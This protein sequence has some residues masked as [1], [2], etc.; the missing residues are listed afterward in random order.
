MFF[1]DSSADK[2]ISWEQLIEEIHQETTSEIFCKE[3]DY[4]QIFKKII[5]SLLANREIVLFDFDFSEE[6]TH[7]LMQ[8]HGIFNETYTLE[9]FSISSKS[10]LISQCRQVSENWKIS[11]F[12]SGTTGQPKRIQPTFQSI[13]RFLT[14]KSQPCVWG[15][16]YHPTHMAGLQVFFQSFLNGNTLVRLFGLNKELIHQTIAHSGI[17]HI[18]A[19]PTFYRLLL[20]TSYTHANVQRITA[21]GERF[22]E[23][24]F[25][26]L[27]AIFPQAKI[28]NIYAS[29]EAGAVLVSHGSFFEIKKGWEHLVKIE[30]NELLLHRSVLGQFDHSSEWY[31]TGDLVSF[32]EENPQQFKFASRSSELI[33]VGGY[34]VNPGEVEEALLEIEGISEVWVYGRK[35]AVMGQLVCCEIV[36]SNP[37]LDISSIKQHLAKRLQ[38]FKIPRIIKFVEK[39]DTT[40]TGKLKRTSA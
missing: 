23:T 6:E 39:L 12:T 36:S 28:N 21:G 27:T 18:S 3:P 34:K 8:Q 38:E 13:T 31:H 14:F 11:L 10:D 29:T 20:P 22:D 1:I 40:R 4:F 15:F 24:L 25:E 16:A 33:H 5:L 7:N 37:S 32:S 2:S 30:Q 17:T 26:K 9:K 19:T 35:N